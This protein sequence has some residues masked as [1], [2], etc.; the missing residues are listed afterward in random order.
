MIDSHCH[1]ADPDIAEV[2]RITTANAKAFF[3]LHDS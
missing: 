1:L 2:D 3:G